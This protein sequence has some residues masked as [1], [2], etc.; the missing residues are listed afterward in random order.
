MIDL[1]AFPTQPGV[2]LMKNGEGTI[3]Y[4]GKAKQLKQRIKQYFIPGRDGRVMV[5]ILTA[6]VVSIDTIVVPTEK[7]ALLLEST[8][9]KRHKPKFNVLLKDDKTFISLMIN[10]KHPWPMIR[11][12]RYKGVPKQEGLYF[13]PF[14]NALAA[15]QTFELLT[16]IFPLRQCSDEELKRRTRPCLLYS[17]KRC[18]APCVRRCSRE[19]YQGFVK[20]A[21]HFLQGQ[22]KEILKELKKEMEKAS[23]NLEFEKAAALLKTIRQIED[24]LEHDKLSVRASKDCDAL[25]LY[26]QGGEVM[27]VQLIFREGNLIGS[28]HYSFEQT[29]EED[30]DI[31]TSFILQNYQDKK[32]APKELL[33]PIILQDASILEEIVG[34]EIHTPHKGEKRILID[35]ALQNAKMLFNQEKDHQEQREKLLLDLTTALK[36]NRYPKRIEC[37]DTSNISGSDLVACMVAY[38]D[39]EKDRRR[40]RLFKIRDIHKSDDYA[41]LRQVL[42]RRLVRAKE[43]EDLPDLILIDGG[44]GQLNIALEV[45]KELDIATVDVAALAKEEGRHD[46][47]I[48]LEKVFL[49]HQTEPIR[50]ESRSPLLFFL[51]KIRDDTHETAI[52]FHRKRRQKRVIKSALDEVPGIGAIKR[53]RLLR[54]FGSIEKLRTASDA[55]ILS[56]KG[57]TRKDLNS[58]RQALN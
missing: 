12:I 22:N 54:Y 25:G 43:E 46:K 13:G 36:L 14:T 21:I 33:V 35:L 23:E 9:I 32:N 55:E 56:L 27:L 19:E 30:P 58:I 17:I 50:F 47:G 51:Q 48:R 7:E 26:R 49:P 20:G 10:H 42:T 34:I 1:N 24:V 39:G 57:I 5:P 52:S 16:R 29:A 18:I 6:Q 2:Y 31:F 11:L 4:I 37:F 38:T 40:R 53:S 15:R 41:A 45:F 44:K 28:E 8:L 3:L